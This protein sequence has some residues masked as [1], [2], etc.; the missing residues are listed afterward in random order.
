MTLQASH[1]KTA[2]CWLNSPLCFK[3]EIDLEGSN[4]LDQ[5]SIQFGHQCHLNVSCLWFA[6]CSYWWLWSCCHWI[7]HHCSF[8]MQRLQ[9][10]LPAWF[11]LW[12]WMWSPSRCDCVLLKRFFQV[13]RCHLFSKQTHSSL[14]LV[15]L[16][17]SCSINNCIPIQN[18]C[19]GKN[20]SHLRVTW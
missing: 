19:T 5:C 12:R 20:N 2:L 9:Q 6:Y 14:V 4:C 11:V 7:S 17:S 18:L 8:S 13:W 3:Y 1:S 15:V 10:G 16:N